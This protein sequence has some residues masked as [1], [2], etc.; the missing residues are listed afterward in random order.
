MWAKPMVVWMVHGVF[1]GGGMYMVWNGDLHMRALT[2]LILMLLRIGWTCLILRCAADAKF[3]AVVR[4][5][6]QRRGL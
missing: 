6:A 4:M 2:F 1:A 5:A 3:S